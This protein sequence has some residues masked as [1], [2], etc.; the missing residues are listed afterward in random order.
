[1]L[2]DLLRYDI[3]DGSW[4][5][6][7]SVG[8]PPA[9]RYHHSAVVY[10]SSMFIFGGY[11]GDIHSNS[12]LV[13]FKAHL[14]QLTPIWWPFLN[15]FYRQTEMICGSI[16]LVVDI[17]LNGKILDQ[18][19]LLQGQLMG[20]QFMTESCIFL[21][22]KFLIHSIDLPNKIKKYLFETRLWWK[23]EIKWHV[24]CFTLEHYGPRLDILKII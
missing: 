23:H 24:G 17:G 7:F 21:Q 14:M 3:R 19:D 10:G 8:H 16:N 4:V 22:V 18:S 12:N 1:M 20:Q 2:S 9:P 13:S 6:A 15:N 5:R 11:T